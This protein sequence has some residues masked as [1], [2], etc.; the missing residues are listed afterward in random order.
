MIDKASIIFSWNY[1]ECDVTPG[2][3][4]HLVHLLTSL[5][6]GRVALLLEGGYNVEATAN[7]MTMCVRALLGDPLPEP[8]A[9]PV[10]PAGSAAIQRVIQHLQPYWSNLEPNSKDSNKNEVII[11]LEKI[12]QENSKNALIM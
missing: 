12:Q 1:L 9:T 2:G 6:F 5:A 11:D 4:G 10:D 7:S 8:S 3:Y